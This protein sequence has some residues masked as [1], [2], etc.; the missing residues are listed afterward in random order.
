MLP[1]YGLA[2]GDD[3]FVS[4]KF[5]VWYTNNLRLTNGIKIEC[6][7]LLFSLFLILFPISHFL[8]FPHASVS[9]HNFHGPKLIFKIPEH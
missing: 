7:H 3:D 8:C 2:E 9:Y 1:N 6:T 5:S 4:K